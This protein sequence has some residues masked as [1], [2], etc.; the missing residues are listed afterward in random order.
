M[1]LSILHAIA[2]LRSPLLDPILGFL[3]DICSFGQV[4]ILISLVMVFYKKTRFIGLTALVALFLMQFSGNMLLKPLI[5]RPRP[6]VVDPTLLWYVHM[7]SDFSFPSGHTASSFAAAFV[8][9]FND[10]RIGIPAL[11][12]AALISF[13][14]L[15]FGVH[16]PTDI[17]GGIVLGLICATAAL[18]LMRKLLKQK[19]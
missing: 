4:W 15:Y 7:P 9:F 16:Y 12:L 2:Q 19:P 17:L 1:E 8:Y 13:T 3:T 14:R 6:F 18:F 10:R 5:A 11:V